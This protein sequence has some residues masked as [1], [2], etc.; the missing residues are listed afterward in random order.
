MK[1]VRF[2]LSLSLLFVIGCSSSDDFFF[3]SE[4]LNKIQNNTFIIVPINVYAPSMNEEEVHYYYTHNCNR[5]LISPRLQLNCKHLETCRGE[6]CSIP[7]KTHGTAFLLEKGDQL[8]T[9]WHVAFES[10]SAAILFLQNH[11]TSKTLEESRQWTLNSIHPQFVLLNH[12]REIVYD[13]RTDPAQYKMIGNPTTPVHHIN[14]RQGDNFYGYHENIPTDWTIIDLSHSLGEGLKLASDVDKDNEEF[15]NAGFGFDRYQMRFSIDGG[16]R[17]NIY[18]LNKLLGFDDFF[19]T[20]ENYSHEELMAMELPEFLSH[21]GY[22]SESIE[23]QMSD[24]S[25]EVLENSR[26]VVVRLQQRHQ[27][28]LLLEEREDVLFL[29]SKSL[30]GH[31]GCPLLNKKGEVVG[32]VST[33]FSDSSDEDTP[34]K[35]YGTGALVFKNSEFMSYLEQ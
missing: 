26:N 17:E 3:D 34:I 22:S 10:H 13:T 27:R 2:F 12:K 18:N 32:L 7:F 1:F 19:I 6:E 4:T 11:Y 33:G 35:P 30:P 15:Y 8:V 29:N 24:Y 14:G 23:E 9:A 31:S 28:D 5:N 25:D 20:R 21:M 16:K